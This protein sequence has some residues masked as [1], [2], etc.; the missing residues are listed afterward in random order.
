MGV[1]VGRNREKVGRK[2]EKKNK[3]H[4]EGGLKDRKIW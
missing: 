1:A 2:G 4:G 3:Y